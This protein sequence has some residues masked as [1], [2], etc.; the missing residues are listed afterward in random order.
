MRDDLATFGKQMGIING[1]DPLL[2]ILQTSF[3]EFCS[4]ITCMDP[5]LHI[6]QTSFS[7]FCSIITCMDP[8]FPR[9]DQSDLPIGNYSLQANE[10]I[11]ELREIKTATY[12]NQKKE[13]DYV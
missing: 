1:M 3:S 12:Y 4:I 13:F 2:H 9:Q 5:L 11:I 6:L 7:E 8:L 10:G